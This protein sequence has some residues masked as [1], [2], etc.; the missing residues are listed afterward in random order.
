MVRMQRL[1]QP[2]CLAICGRCLAGLR[3]FGTHHCRIRPGQVLMLC[4]IRIIVFTS[5]AASR[6]R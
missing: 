5:G 4:R 6:L 2:L 3:W 1:A